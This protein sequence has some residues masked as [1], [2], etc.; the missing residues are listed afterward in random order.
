MKSL[1][2]A[3]V[4]ALGLVGTLAAQETPAPATI[5]L[6]GVTWAG[7]AVSMKDL[8][9]K[10]VA[11]LVYAS[12]CPKCNE[13]SGELFKQLK[14]AIEGKPAVILAIYADENPSRAQQYVTERSFFAP[15]IVHG[16]D[17]G[18]PKKLGFESNLFN[19]VLVDASGAIVDRG[20]AGTAIGG[21]DGRKFILA[22]ALANPK[23]PG[24]FR[25]MTEAMS[26][27]VRQVLWP[28]ELGTASD[29]VVTKAR[30]S[31]TAEQKQEL[32]G[33]VERFME[34]GLD[35]VKGLYKG[36]IEDRFKAHDKATQLATVFKTTPQSKKARDVASFLEKDEE[37]KR[38]LAAKKA[39]DG[40]MLKGGPAG[41][42]DVL[43]KSIAKRFEGTHYG[44]LADEAAQ[45]N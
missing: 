44:K 24:S 10:T 16:F 15:N 5:P 39:Y 28:L 6:D 26:E 25:L 20:S 33:A 30:G 2:V 23:T 17:P 43:L 22:G 4:V 37:F 1:C 41:K 7:P 36:S 29:A 40:C 3:V 34:T 35:E 32:D 31:L 9:G 21:A 42:R 8:E 11:V 14:T 19:F 12:W 18:M 38:E 27:P 13:W 45:K